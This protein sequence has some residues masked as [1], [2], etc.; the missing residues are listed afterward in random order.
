MESVRLK[1]KETVHKHCPVVDKVV[2]QGDM[3]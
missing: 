2:S 3:V 1:V